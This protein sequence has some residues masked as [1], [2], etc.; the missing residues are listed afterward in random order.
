M[1][2]RIDV[3]PQSPSAGQSPADAGDVLTD[4]L[5]DGARRLL[6]QALE[7]ESQ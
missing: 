3:T 1:T 6:A 2:L 5:R 4:R 7:A